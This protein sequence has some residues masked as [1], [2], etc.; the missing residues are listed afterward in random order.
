MQYLALKTD[1]TSTCMTSH[2]KSKPP[3]DEKLGYTGFRNSRSSPVA[4]RTDMMERR[5]MDPMTRGIKVY[6]ATFAITREYQ[7]S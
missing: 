6:I 3:G 2:T 5:E 1:A 4:S 7:I